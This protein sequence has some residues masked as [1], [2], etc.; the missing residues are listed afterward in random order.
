MSCSTTGVTSS[1][2]PVTD[3][4]GALLRRGAAAGL[5][6][7]VLAGLFGLVAG[8]PAIDELE[9][10]AGGHAA[11]SH[12]DSAAAEDVPVSRA[13]QRAGLVAG[14]GFAGA[15]AGLVLAVAFAW[16]HGRMEGD[17]WR[18]S[19]L[20]GA[21]AV[22]ALV[23]LPTLAYPAMPPG[24]APGTVGTRSLLH[25]A[26]ALFGLALAAAGR[27]ANRRLAGSARPLRHVTVAAGTLA[28][29]AVWVVA[30][31]SSAD[32]GASMPDVPA[33]LLWDYRLAV[34]ATQLVLVGGTAVVF[35]LLAER[36][37]A[38]TISTSAAA[39]PG[40][41]ARGRPR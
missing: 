35:G 33:D 40:V 24:S 26:T 4:L 2:S 32:L 39:R 16:S 20:L 13:V 37:D 41:R 30:V 11:D 18:R 8:S 6:A 12:D 14:T 15:A 23:V 7:G 38:R 10:A 21:T 27:A 19:L 3:R 1:A 28:A 29:A 25:I 31:P 22:G 5:I 9:A 17:A 36:A 34:A